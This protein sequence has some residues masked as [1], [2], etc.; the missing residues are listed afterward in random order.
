MANRPTSCARVKSSDAGKAHEMRH[1][2]LIE[3]TGEHFPCTDQESVLAAMTR[4][5][6]RGIPAGCRGGG[7]GICKVQVT[8]GE[9]QCRPMSR[10]HVS[11]ADQSVG[12]VLA[13][14]ITA[15]SDLSLRVLGKMRNSV[16]KGAE[17]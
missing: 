11:L 15:R 3:D 8:H 16:C 7:C 17:R 9:Y 14:C 13:C 12:I 2:A 1:D 5:G 4:I 6:R 10:S